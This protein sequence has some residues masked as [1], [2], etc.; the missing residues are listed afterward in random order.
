VDLT[1]LVFLPSLQVLG[2]PQ[3]AITDNATFAALTQMLTFRRLEN[4]QIRVIAI[5]SLD[6]IF[7]LEQPRIGPNSVDFNGEDVKL[8]EERVQALTQDFGISVDS[9]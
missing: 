7:K 3:L 6:L 4:T 1:P 9:V 2:I 5:S 8:Y